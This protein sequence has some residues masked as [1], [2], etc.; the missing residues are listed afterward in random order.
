MNDISG[1]NLP[2]HAMLI[3]DD[4]L[5][6]RSVR[7]ILTSIGVERIEEAADGQSALD[8]LRGAAHPDVVICDLRM[9]NMDGISLLRHFA[10]EGY[11]GHFVIISGEDD[12]LI[13]SVAELARARGLSLL[14]AVEKPVRR[15]QLETL[16]TLAANTRPF[17]APAGHP[18][19]TVS[20]GD[21]ARLLANRR[22]A[23]RLSA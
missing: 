5:L 6:R 2:R 16:M 10:A 19:H 18:H 12:R 17:T 1:K 4:E 15:S 3:D 23:R 11:Q 22:V 13:A 9:P 14:G 21:L 8:L 20:G 7:R